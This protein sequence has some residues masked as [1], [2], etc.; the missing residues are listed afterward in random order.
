MLGLD[1]TIAS[2]SGG[3]LAM[4]LAVAVLLGVR[5]A[6]DPDHLTAVSTLVLSE[7]GEG[8]PGA[9]RLGLAWGLG[10]AVTLTALG[11]PFVLLGTRLPGGLQR[12]AEV[13]VGTLIA[14]LA[15]RLLVRWR[16]GCFHTHPHSHGAVRHS[17]P[18]VHDHG[19]AEPHPAVHSHAHAESLGRSPL[20]AFGIGLLH[21]AGGSAAVGVLIVGTTASTATA[22]AALALFAAA[23]MAS[24]GLV[25]AL[26]GYGLRRTRA[27]RRLA[28]AIPAFGVLSL[29]FGAWYALSAL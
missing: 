27:L 13:A 23:T 18:H 5:H 21:G 19:D 14:A 25:T 4:A 8:A 10:H 9:G 26:F 29:T 28:A 24:M 7:R 15:C 17:H 16:R 3:G 6:T 1:D 12:A 22:V 11:L 20:A 2:L